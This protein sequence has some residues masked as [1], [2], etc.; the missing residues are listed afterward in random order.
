MRA[1]GEPAYAIEP[2]F[3]GPRTFSFTYRDKYY[4]F[5]YEKNRGE[6]QVK[7]DEQGSDLAECNLTKDEYEI[8]GIFADECM[9][10]TRYYINGVKA[11]RAGQSE[12]LLPRTDICRLCLTTESGFVCS[13][14]ILSI[15]PNDFECEYRGCRYGFDIKKNDYS[16]PD[17]ATPT[18]FILTAEE[19]RIISLIKYTC[20]QSFQ[21]YINTN[22]SKIKEVVSK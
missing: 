12:F 13:F 14:R 17:V 6:G 22:K 16:I 20:T 3:I 19:H 4:A 15:G 18:D 2:S 9:R 1:L 11:R 7:Y 8:M 5:K 21:R 10:A